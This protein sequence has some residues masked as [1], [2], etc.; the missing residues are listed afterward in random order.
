MQTKIHQLQERDDLD[1]CSSPYCRCQSSVIYSPG[2][3]RAN[4]RLKLTFCDEHH[5]D[6]LNQLRPDRNVERSDEEV[7]A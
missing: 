3:T 5:S 6:F 7:Q 4:P 1:Q 2:A